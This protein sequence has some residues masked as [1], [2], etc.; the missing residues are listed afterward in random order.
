MNANTVLIA[1]GD[2]AIV[3]LTTYIIQKSYGGVYVVS[4]SDGVEA[5]HQ[6]NK[7]S[8]PLLILDLVMPRK[9]GID[10]L[11]ESFRRSACYCFL[12]TRELK[13]R[14]RKAFRNRE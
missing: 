11:K 9:S 2:R 3:Q 5:L 12:G 4:A 8:L 13:R 10:V 6:I 1:D 14:G 7:H